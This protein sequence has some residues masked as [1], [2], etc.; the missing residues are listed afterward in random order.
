MKSDIIAKIGQ[1]DILLPSLIADGLRANNQVK[2]RLSVLQAAARHARGP[3]GPRF[4]LAAECR[5][6]DLDPVRM[7]TLV[8]G[9]TLVAGDRIAAP[10]L[11]AT[12]AAIWSDVATMAHAV[13]S[14]APDQGR[15]ARARLAT[16]EPRASPEPAD[17]LDLAQ[18]AQLTRIGEGGGDSLHR[19][20]MDLHKDLNRLA[21]AQAEEVVAGA[22]A[23]GLHAEDRRAVEAFM[24][25]LES[26][27][28][29]KFDHPGLATTAMRSG[30]RLIIQND[31]GETDA[32]VVVIGID[33]DAVT[34]T[35]TDVHLAR[36]RFFV[37][38]FR[39]FAVEWSGLDRKSAEGLGD[40]G[41]FYLVTG[42]HP[43]A[44]L[45]ARD[46]FLTALGAALV[47]LIDWNKARKVLRTF[48]PKSDAVTVLEWAAQ[49]RVGHRAFLELGGSELVAAAVHHAAPSRIGFGDRLDDTLGRAGAV[50]FLKAVL[51]ISAEA[52]LRGGS[53]RL[54]RDR[55][56]A[57]LV[58][59][60]QRVDGALLEI[61]IRQAGIARDI[62]AAV[63][64]AIREPRTEPV[65]D[66]TALA[67]RARRME[68]KADQIAVEAR[69]EIER[70]DANRGIEL[71]VDRMEDAIDELE[72]AAFIASLLPGDLAPELL[73]PLSALSAGAV[74]ATEA[75]AS[76]VAAAIDVS[77]GH[78]VDCED[79]LAAVG[80]LIRV[81]HEADDAERAVTAIALRGAF[82]LRASLSALELA[83][84]LE[85]S[86][87]RLASFGHLLRARVL[88][89]LA[90]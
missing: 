86:T 45:P 77:A 8:N 71:L 67:V 15:S 12:V 44:D 29:L 55:I 17:T 47:F 34:V 42:R 19:L 11:A 38:L 70:F 43:A 60:L 89:E 54:A 6:V 72:Q 7:E 46:R 31:I 79:S 33:A 58:R 57:E 76:G 80:R 28:R 13:E 23:Y 37:N 35:Y 10:G 61:V 53:V 62:A 66:R 87:D 81:E 82:D 75:A 25:G 41:V 26:T 32:H 88:V 2:A 3:D 22:H 68:E 90:N 49:H 4:D 63:E 18:V 9:A 78:Q 84:A 64:Q 30:S 59:H 83:R 69:N 52:L 65:R 14:G 5:A 40:D 56:E 50:D 39:D 27:A 24:R 73:A 85:R 1:T 16:L 21:A 74:S 20:V 48:V 51:R 36:T